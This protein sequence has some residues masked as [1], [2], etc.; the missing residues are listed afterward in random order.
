M[1]ISS[2]EHLALRRRINPRT[3]SCHRGHDTIRSGLRT[4][5]TFGHPRISMNDISRQG[6]IFSSIF[7]ARPSSRD[8]SSRTWNSVLEKYLV[9][10][11]SS[12]NNNFIATKTTSPSDILSR[13]NLFAATIPRDVLSIHR[14]FLFFISR[15]I[16]EISPVKDHSIWKRIISSVRT[17]SSM[18]ILL[19][20]I[21]FSIRE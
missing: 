4:L 7:L 16:P 14:Y 15:D 21:R 1:R 10:N 13:T 2:N 12:R 8:I 19:R 20:I 5:L 3:L 6:L 11:Y 17:T 9:N 18:D